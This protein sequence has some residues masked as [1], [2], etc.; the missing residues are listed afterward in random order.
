[1]H[2]TLVYAQGPHAVWRRGIEL[3][4][5]S[6]VADAINASGFL[7]L[8]PEQELGRLQVGIFGRQ[9]ALDRLLDEGDLIEIYR[10]LVFDPMES[11]RRRAQHKQ[12][13]LSR[14]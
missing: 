11:R 2:I 12:K 9:V 7:L 14:T 5:G 13:G 10:P 3:P 6:S 8:Y 4:A 1:M